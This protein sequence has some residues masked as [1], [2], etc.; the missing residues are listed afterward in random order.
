[1]KSVIKNTHP[2]TT[3]KASGIFSLLLLLISIPYR[4][5]LMN[6]SPNRGIILTATTYAT[7]D[8][9]TFTIIGNHILMTRATL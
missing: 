3:P 7:T 8:T 5:A 6:M 9:M 2:V 1:M 4:F